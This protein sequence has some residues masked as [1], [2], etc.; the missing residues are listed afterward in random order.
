[1]GSL[2]A[3]G[4]TVAECGDGS[5]LDLVV[6]ARWIDEGRLDEVLG[7]IGAAIR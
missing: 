2:T 6:V 7:A 5:S 4:W 1:V 3:G